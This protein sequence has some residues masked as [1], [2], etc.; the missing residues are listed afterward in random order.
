MLRPWL[1]EPSSFQ[2]VHDAC[3][4]AVEK[5][6]AQ[7]AKDTEDAVRAVSIELARYLALI[8]GPPSDVDY[9]AI[10]TVRRCKSDR[11]SQLRLTSAHCCHR[12]A[13]IKPPSKLDTKK[14]VKC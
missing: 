5:A 10:W 7:L 4:V 1:S 2:V 14:L 8:P 6:M 13:K 9:W 11:T 3:R 12:W